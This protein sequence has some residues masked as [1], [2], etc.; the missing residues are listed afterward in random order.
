MKW[1]PVTG[2]KST[3]SIHRF[4][5]GKRALG[6]RFF[7]RRVTLPSA[8]T[9]PPSGNRPPESRPSPEPRDRHDGNTTT[10]TS[11]APHPVEV[12]ISR[13]CA[14]ALQ[15]F[16]RVLWFGRVSSELDFITDPRE[17]AELLHVLG[18][19]QNSAR[20]FAVGAIPRADLQGG[21]LDLNH[22]G[23]GGIGF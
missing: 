21:F 14:N 3:G 4:S 19:Q 8:S 17:Q 15:V 7:G 13:F 12:S 10:R 1:E 18:F 9:D 6:S 20:W 23:G 16:P 2:M 22:L 5:P 11:P